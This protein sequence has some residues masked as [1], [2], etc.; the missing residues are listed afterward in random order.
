MYSIVR[1][2]CKSLLYCSF[3]LI[4]LILG[5]DLKSTISVIKRHPAL[6]EKAAFIIFGLDDS[7]KFEIKD[8]VGDIDVKD[9]GFSFDC[10]YEDAIEMVE[11]KAREMGANAFKIYKHKQP[12]IWSSCHRIKAKALFLE[13]LWQYEKEIKWSSKRKLKIR[14]F[15]GDTTNKS[16]LAATASGIKVIWG[17]KSRFVRG[18][19]EVVTFYDCTESYF[20][21]KKDSVHVLA[22][23]QLHFD[24]SELYARKF[25]KTIRNEFPA[26]KDFMLK[27]DSIYKKA[28]LDLS[29]AQDTYDLEVYSDTSRQQIWFAKIASEL[30]SYE[31]FS[32]KSIKFSK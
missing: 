21:D 31:S 20:R 3:L 19:A 15:K 26:F 12:D 6:D 2:Y 28:L 17:R 29:L 5:C 14:D 8:I 1:F 27:S 10:S 18:Y 25:V 22:H 13:D 24:I 7:I 4:M 32:N 23:E 16:A 11:K 9:S 30:K